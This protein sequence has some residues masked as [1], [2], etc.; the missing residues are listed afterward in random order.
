MAFKHKL[1]NSTPPPIPTPGFLTALGVVKESTTSRDKE[2]RAPMFVTKQPL[3][4][5]SISFPTLT[6]NMCWLTVE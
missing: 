1:T 3:I 5:K 2:D 6:S 4:F